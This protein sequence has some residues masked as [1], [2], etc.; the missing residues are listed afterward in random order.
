MLSQKADKS[1]G[2]YSEVKVI[3]CVSV[4][5]EDDIVPHTLSKYCKILRKASS[6]VIIPDE[7]GQC[8]RVSS[9]LPLP[10]VCLVSQKLR[11]KSFRFFQKKSFRY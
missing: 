2:I 1:N 10:T 3:S 9:P 4:L 11:K 6:T 7:D 8:A 5:P